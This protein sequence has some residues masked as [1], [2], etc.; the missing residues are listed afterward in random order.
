MAS[1]FRPSESSRPQLTAEQ[2]RQ[3]QERVLVGERE[4]MS[5]NKARV[6]DP[7]LKKIQR[8]GLWDGKKWGEVKNLGWLLRNWKGVDGF[9]V[10]ESLAPGNNQA[11]LIAYCEDG[12]VYA[13][14]YASKAVLAGWL[15]R[16]V[17]V[18]VPVNWFGEHHVIGKELVTKYGGR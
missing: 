18:G 3:M 12:R 14:P 10:T 16:P 9:V 11:T 7:A 2:W 6:V 8:S 17:F 5:R 15:N 13:T 1:M 4:R